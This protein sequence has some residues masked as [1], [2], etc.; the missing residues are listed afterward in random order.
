MKKQLG[1]GYGPI[2]PNAH[3]CL[4]GAWRN[5]KVAWDQLKAAV[6]HQR[7]GF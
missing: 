5:L 4:L 2:T 1:F 6:R 7:R 3:R